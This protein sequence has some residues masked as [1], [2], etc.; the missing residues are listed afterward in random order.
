VL[1]IK[2]SAVR[3][4][5]ASKSASSP[6]AKPLATIQQPIMTKSEYK[7]LDNSITSF[8]LIKQK[9]EQYWERID[10]DACWGFQIQQKSKWKQGLT[11]QQIEDFQRQLGIQFPESLIN[12]YKT[13]NGLDKPG[14]NNNGGESEIQFG[15]TFYSYPDD[16]EKIKS[17]IDWILKDNSVTKEVT[18][19]LNLPAIVPYLGH[20]FLILDEEELVLSMYGSDIIFWAENLSKGIASDIFPSHPKVG[21]EKVNTN[22][23]WNKKALY[24]EDVNSKPFRNKN[25]L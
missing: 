18:A 21:S 10:L 17:Q 16:V 20:R 22:S 23:F 1:R 14:L 8:E 24:L 11:Q 25:V 5:S 7:K 3:Q 9:S 4:F 12:Y 15:P 6:S 19:K 2:F 13:M